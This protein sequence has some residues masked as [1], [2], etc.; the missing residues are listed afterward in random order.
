MKNHIHVAPVLDALREPGLCPFCT[1]HQKLDENAAE[2][3]MGPAYMDE[4]IRSK[5]N[6]AGFCRRHLDKLYA[7]QNKLGL[8]LMLHTHLKE[9]RLQ[10]SQTL[11]CYSCY[12]CDKINETFMR[13]M[14]TFFYMWKKESTPASGILAKK[15]I[16]TPF[17]KSQHEGQHEGNEMRGLIEALPGFCLPHYHLMIDMSVKLLKKKHLDEFLSVV[18]PLQQ[19]ALQK[20]DGDLDW[21]TKKFDH[22]Y[23]DEPWKDSKDAITRTI[24]ILKGNT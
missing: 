6:E 19:Q 1:M 10:S 4:D 24:A 13:Y 11:N 5:T 14:D 20:L 23:A 2:F 22:R 9:V 12:L 21:F 16:M 15:R 17:V 3:I 8:A 18:E 7:M